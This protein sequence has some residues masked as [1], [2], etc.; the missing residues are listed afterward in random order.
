MRRF[1]GKRGKSAATTGD[2]IRDNVEQVFIPTPENG[3]YTVRLT[4]KG[5]LSNGWQTASLLLSGNIPTPRT[6]LK[7]ENFSTGSGTNILEWTAV[8]GAFYQVR[9]RTN[10]LSGS[11]I[12]A[13]G[14]INA[15][16]PDLAATITTNDQSRTR[17]FKLQEQN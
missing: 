10:L 14:E 17:F 12:E 13:T 6:P 15:L 8:P 4:H 2:N 1:P 7:I 16:R 11:W 9:T 5:T 3:N